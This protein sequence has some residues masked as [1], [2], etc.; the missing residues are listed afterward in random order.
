MA[1]TSDGRALVYE[2]PVNCVCVRRLDGRL[3]RRW[4]VPVTNSVLILALSPDDRTLLTGGLQD[5]GFRLW[6]ITT[7]KELFPTERSP[8]VRP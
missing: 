4:D 6:D 2:E 1:L 3:V 5:P 7:G 8:A